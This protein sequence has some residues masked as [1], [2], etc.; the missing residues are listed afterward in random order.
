MLFYTF[1][2]QEERRKFGGSYFIEIQYCKLPPS[3]EIKQRV[4]VDGIE[5]WKNDSLYIYG[6]DD[7]QFIQQYGEIFSCG[8]YNNGEKG[9]VAPYGI[10]YYSQEQAKNIVDK[11][12]KQK[13][14]DYPILLRWLERANEATGFY[15]L[16]L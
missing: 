7:N 4:S 2:T 6:D 10:N 15:I 5:H 11:V 14:S 1:H 13:P 16:G 3:S 8:I 9:P 12:Q